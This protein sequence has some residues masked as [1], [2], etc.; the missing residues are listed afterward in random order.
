MRVGLG[1]GLSIIPQLFLETFWVRGR[2][3]DNAYKPNF[4]TA[5]TAF[6]ADE[7]CPDYRGPSHGRHGFG[8]DR[9]R[10]IAA[11]VVV[12]PSAS[13]ARQ[14]M[15]TRLDFA[16]LD[17]EVTDDQTF[18]IALELQRNEVPFVFVSGSAKIGAAFSPLQ[19]GYPPP[20]I[21]VIWERVSGPGP[22][23]RRVKGSGGAPSPGAVEPRREKS[24]IV[25]GAVYSPSA[26]IA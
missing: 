14:A 5:R 2:C 23:S 25:V 8:I 15:I 13:G 19:G 3:E 26:P 16:F 20:S 11:E 1:P 7:A 10:G 17:I 4:A 18:E 9:L 12:V 21:I 6:D 22:F 24:A